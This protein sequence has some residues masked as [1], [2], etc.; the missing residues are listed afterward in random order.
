MDILNV[1]KECNGF[2]SFNPVQEKAIKKNVLEKS[3]VISSPTSSGKTL[4]A[5]I[6]ALNSVLNKRKK[7]V[8]TCPLRALASEH[9][10]DFKKK[11]GEKFSIK[12]V[13]S[14][15]DFDSSGKY[16][17][18]KD[19]IFTTYEKLNSLLNNNSEWL[20]EIGLLVVDEIHSL[21]SDRGAT[22]EMVITKLRFLNKDLQIIGLSATIP[23]AKQISKWLDAELIES[24]YRPVKL[25]EGVYLDEKIDFQ[26]SSEEIEAHVD[27]LSSIAL[28]TLGKKK[29]AL[30]FAN[31]RRSSEATAKKLALITEKVLSEEEKLVLKKASE[32]ILSVLEQPTTQCKTLANLIQ[33]GA[34]FH[35]AGLLQKQRVIIE[36]LFKARY[37]KFI[38]STPTLCV[39]PETKIWQ[40]VKD[41]QVGGFPENQSVMAL[42]NNHLAYIKPEEVQKIEN[43]KDIITIGSVSGNNIKTTSNHRIFVKRKGKKIF[44]PAEECRK[45]D[46][47]ATVGK[48]HRADSNELNT[49]GKF[50]WLGKDFF[51]FIGCMLGDGYSGAETGKECIK[52]K[53]TPCIVGIDS[54]VFKYS[55]LVSS[56]LGLKY[57]ESCNSF[58]VPELFLSKEKWFRE[59]LVECGVEKGQ[60]KFIADELKSAKLDNISAL[61][62]GLFD[63]DGHVNTGRSLGFSNISLNLIND[64]KRLLLLFGV[65]SRVRKRE[66]S[67]INLTGKKYFTKEYYEI[68]I[69]QK[70][71]ILDF[72]SKIGFRIKRKNKALFNIVTS[73]KSN[74]HYVSCSKCGYKLFKDIFSGRNKTHK[75]WGEQK[76]AIIK[77]LGSNGELTSRQLN[78]IL[79]FIPYKNECRLNHHFELIERKKKGTEKI[80]GL[81]EIGKV[82]YNSICNNTIENLFLSSDCKIC[83][84]KLYKKIKSGWR[85]NDFQGDI[86]WDFIKSVKK[87]DKSNYPFVYDVVLPSDG[88]NDHLFAAEG[89]LI[90]NSAGV[91]LPAF[92][93]VIQSPYRY[94]GF[95][96]QRIP[97]AEYKQMCGRAGRPKYDSEG[98]AILIAKTEL[99]KD[100]YFDYFVNGEIEDVD[101]KLASES[102]LRFHLLSAIASG[103]IFDL[104]SAEQFF[105]KTFYAEQSCDLSYLFTKVTSIV[106]GLEEMGFVD[107]D[108][109]RIDATLLGKRVVQLYLDPDSAFRII[110]SLRKNNFA[111]LSYLFL[112]T[113]TIEFFPLLNV[114]KNKEL[115]LWELIQEEKSLLPVNI[116]VEMYSDN[117]LLQKYWTS[118]LLKEWISEVKEQALVDEFKI[119]PG[120]LRAKL[121]NADWLAYSVLE[122]AKVLGFEDHF[123]YLN[124][125]RKRLKSGIKEELVPLC[126]LR[127][128]GRV[129]ARRM[130]NAGIKS[131]NDVKKIDV[132]D[133]ERVLSPKIAIKVKAQLTLKK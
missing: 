11:Y 1:V 30:F 51:Y 4:I 130:F 19:V 76:L 127:G 18:S 67:S 45:G 99:E 97:V 57:R 109:N 120:I 64:I 73:I 44:L 114:P 101:S 46:K 125:I 100:D 89:F 106:R 33:R 43:Y 95:G 9:S 15:G 40:G 52:F 65:V 29:Q 103:F 119:Q 132:K 48:I 34:C 6:A 112:I 111:D 121:S 38:S 105:S 102:L 47:I 80:W 54:E 72:Y 60:N 96:M 32:K 131:I 21:G 41:F 108:E 23:N 7:V 93:V 129:R 82:V 104:D 5:E 81:N 71:S 8:Y 58:G 110:T 85:E 59:L 92:R 126:E 66:G 39:V 14:T 63:T 17:S 56:N 37:L 90:H 118:F 24:D 69:S 16:L 84:S 68:T 94:S 25:K 88:S 77:L 87:E 12:S 62:Q 74:T 124:K 27:I 42:K 98:Q 78:E 128:V 49:K 28:N 22:L 2:D 79:G 3:M 35:N 91:N 123:V 55:K 61:L 86:F 31:T 10:S 53:G 115:E 70:K 117:F 36:D 113:N 83:S 26:N 20:N 107:A 116:D 122:L 13:L 75:E 133:L 50:D